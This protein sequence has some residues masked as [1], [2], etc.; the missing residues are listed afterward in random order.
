MNRKIKQV[1]V[2]RKDL[3]MRKGKMVAQG[4]HASVDSLLGMM[5][6][7]ESSDKAS[8]S[9][10]KRGVIAEWFKEGVAKICLYV[11]SEEELIKIYDES[12]RRKL[13]VSLI[14]DAGLTEFHGEVTKTCLAIG[15]WLSDEIDEVTG[16]LRL[17]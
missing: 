16:S 7:S 9:F 11:E 12:K 13:P 10:D 17:L 2:I 14:E 5:Q 3:N 8:L 1:I 4:A 6:Y 15:P